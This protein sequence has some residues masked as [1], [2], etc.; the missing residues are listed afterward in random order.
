MTYVYYTELCKTDASLKARVDLDF[1][2]IGTLMRDLANKRLD[3]DLLQR[4][5]AD[6]DWDYQQVLVKQI[7][8]VLDQQQ[9]EIDVRP[10]GPG[11]GRRTAAGAADE[12]HVRQP[13]FADILKTCAPY[14]DALQ[15]SERLAAELLAYMEKINFYF[16]EQYLNVIDMLVYVKRSSEQMELW[17]SVLLFLK[18]KMTTLRHNRIGQ[19][20]TDAWLLAQPGAG[21]MPLIA[22]YRFPFWTIV[23]EPLRNLL[24]ER[25]AK[26]SSTS[27]DNVVVLRR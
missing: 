8:I 2:S 3:V 10:G 1:S 17:R 23:K 16:Y 27:T 4:M 20:E 12:I 25:E 7:L 13:A 11:S 26:V 14:I 22:Q 24:G 5:S 15:C 6:F 9:L 18:H 21:M 19:L